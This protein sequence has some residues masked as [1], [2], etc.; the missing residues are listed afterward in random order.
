MTNRVIYNVSYDIPLVRVGVPGRQNRASD[1]VIRIT[2]GMTEVIE[3]WLGN[4]DGLPITLVPFKV[5]IVFWKNISTESEARVLSGGTTEIVFAKE[6][7]VIEPYEGKTLIKFSHQE[8]T[9]IGSR[10]GNLNWSLYMVNSENEVFPAVC[11]SSG[12][13]YGSVILDPGSGLPT[14]EMVL[15]A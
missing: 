8:T 1:G 11:T 12:S 10:G 13:R 7:D 15:S 5:K 9:Q 2:P 4:H 14:A 3:F 6:A